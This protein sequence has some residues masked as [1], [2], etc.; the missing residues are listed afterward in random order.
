MKEV[1]TKLLNTLGWAYWVE[2]K[3]QKP[4]CTYYFGPFLSVSEAKKS[5]QGYVEDLNQE[6]AVGIS[7]EIKRCQP[8]ELTI[9]EE[10]EKGST[11]DFKPVPAF[12]TQS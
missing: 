12:S 7:A 5:Q 4:S 2:I 3:T 9:F 10:E 11:Q 1:L 6:R 8:T